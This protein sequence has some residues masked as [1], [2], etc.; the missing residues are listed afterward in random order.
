MLK[1]FEHIERMEEI[2]LVKKEVGSDVRGLGLRGR[3]R[4]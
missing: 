1:W 3:P 2:W 4:E